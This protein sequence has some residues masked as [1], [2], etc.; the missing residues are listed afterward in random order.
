M[1]RKS[2]ARGARSAAGGLAKPAPGRRFLA[3]GAAALVLFASSLSPSQAADAPPRSA[4]IGVVNTGEPGFR[5]EVLAPTLARLA[6]ALPGASFSTADIAPY[7]AADDIRRT[8]PDFVIGPSDIF[9]GLINNAGAQALAVRQTPF[10]RDANRSVGS[11][12]AVLAAR[13][14]LVSI[15]SLRGKSVTAS[16]PDSLGGWLALEGEMKS[17]GLDAR[18]H[19]GAVTFATYQI[20]EVLRAVLEGKSDAG[21]LSSCQLEIAEASGLVD[22]GALRVIEPREDPSLACAHTTELYPDLVFG[23]LSFEDPAFVRSVTV[24]LLESGKP[25]PRQASKAGSAAAAAFSWQ[26]PGKFDRVSSLYRALEI[27]PWS[28]LRDRSAAGLAKR[29]WKEG[30]AALGFLA[31]L[32]LYELRLKH[33]VAR[34]TAELSSALEE[35]ASALERLRLAGERLDSLQRHALVSQ[36]SSIIAHELKQPIA[37]IINYCA[38][39]RIESEARGEEESET[40]SATE[41]IGEEAR[42]MS[43]IVDRV[44]AYA[45]GRDRPHEPCD[46]GA[47]VKSALASFQNYKDYVPGIQASIERGCLMRG[48]PLELEILALNLLKNA[49]RAAKAAPDPRVRVTVAK[50]GGALTLEVEDSGPALSDADLA[51]VRERGDSTDSEGLGLGLSIVRAIADAHSGSVRFDR[52]SPRGLRATVRFERL[53]PGPAAESKAADTPAGAPASRSQNAGS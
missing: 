12:L 8:A 7:Q 9:L 47:A 5:A 44:R 14:D 33:L 46:L 32:L 38:I 13:K 22:R 51:R 1:R 43:E 36:L 39:Q 41:A 42:R 15:E 18:R 2:S 50:K 25:K 27:G 26:V 52:G 10:A 40:A 49:G 21:V 17:R 31:L 6:E 23:A 30:L 45:K 53:D 34:R 24:A 48:D 29:F 19:F 35:K 20:P 37:S 4:L 28:Y 16:L 3:A 11:A